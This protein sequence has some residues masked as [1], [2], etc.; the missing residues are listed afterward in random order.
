MSS[1]TEFQKNVL[2][3][4]STAATPMEIFNQML[5]VPIINTVSAAMEEKWE[6][7]NGKAGILEPSTGR[8][9]QDGLIFQQN[10]TVNSYEIGSDFRISIEALM[11]YLQET[12][13]NH[14][15][16]A[17]ILADGFGSTLEMT[18]NDLIWLACRS[19]MEVYHYPS[20]ADVVQV[21]GW[22]CR[23]GRNSMRREWR[24][25]DLKTGKTLMRASSLFVLMNKKTRKFSKASEEVMGE[26]KPFFMHFDLPMN[27]DS[28]K[29]QGLDI[30]KAD[31]IRTGLNPGWTDMDVNQH[32]SHIKLV[33][34]VLEG[35]P[36]SVV[37]SDE[38]CAMTLEY[39]KECNM[40]SVLQSLS[41]FSSNHFINN[42]EIELDH[43]LSLECGTE[44]V[45]GRTSWKK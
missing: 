27:K 8:L 31:Y 19:H 41:K 3:I 35:V 37:E 28:R 45:R 26:L 32:V 11:N 44:L 10:F 39:R 23:S 15:K 12:S 9:S 33:N 34:Y 14:F 18:A 16:S 42:Q 4:I 25:R 43:S 17:G 22:M 40:D 30:D 1:L 38:L 21:E 29:L 36:R 7:N 24:I 13:L 2:E 20:W 6:L 5:V